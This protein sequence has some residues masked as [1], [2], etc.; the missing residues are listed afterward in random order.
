MT[1]IQGLPLTSNLYLVEQ[2]CPSLFKHQFL[3]FIETQHAHLIGNN[4][5]HL[6]IIEFIRKGA[7]QLCKLFMSFV[8][9]A[10]NIFIQIH[11]YAYR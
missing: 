1:L 11:N 4:Q 7:Q 3:E 10:S 6:T 2:H 5:R 9:L 8:R